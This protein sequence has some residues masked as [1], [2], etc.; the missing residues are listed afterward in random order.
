MKI[1]SIQ[2]KDLLT[3]SLMLGRGKMGNCWR[4]RKRNIKKSNIWI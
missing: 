1:T 2:Q 3:L 4:W